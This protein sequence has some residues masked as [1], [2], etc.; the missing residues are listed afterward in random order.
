M[1]TE[2]AGS[3]FLQ[4]QFTDAFRSA[5]AARD[6]FSQIVAEHEAREQVR[7]QAAEQKRANQEAFRA[8]YEK[9]PERFEQVK[10]MAASLGEPPPSIENMIER[11][12]SLQQFADYEKRIQAQ[13]LGMEWSRYSLQV[14]QFLENSMGLPKDVCISM[15]NTAGAM[16][17]ALVARQ[18]IHPPGPIAPVVPG[19][20]AEFIFW[21][22]KGEML[23]T[24]SV[25]TGDLQ[26]IE[27]VDKWVA[28]QL[29]NFQPPRITFEAFD[30]KVSD[31]KQS[32]EMARHV[33]ASL[34]K[35][36]ASFSQG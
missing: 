32:G 24:M 20:D 26:S 35:A 2:V 13:H 3:G 19:E 30:T 10:T 5:T 1:V 11:G 9:N 34:S 8:E 18:G 21:T 6:N 29:E 33:A 4:S 25:D 14:R 22:Q 12:I 23:A 28:G 7:T 27:E 15:N 17:T 36:L 16:V 31:K